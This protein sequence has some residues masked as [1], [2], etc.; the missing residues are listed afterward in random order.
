M[1]CSTDWAS[2]GPVVDGTGDLWTSSTKGAVQTAM[3]RANEKWKK[4]ASPLLPP[5]PLPPPILPPPTSKPPNTP[6]FLRLLF[7]PLLVLQP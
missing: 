2:R 4:D 3:D 6:L 5:I 7:V 1:K